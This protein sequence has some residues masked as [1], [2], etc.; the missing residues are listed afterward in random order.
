MLVQ[1]TRLNDGRR[2]ARNL[3]SFLIA[4]MGVSFFAWGILAQGLELNESKRSNDPNELSRS[5]DSRHIN[6]YSLTGRPCIAL[7][8]FVTIQPINKN[9]YG[10]WITASN[11][12]GQS[13]RI[14]VCYHKTDDCIVMNVPPYDNANAVLGIQPSMKE[15]QYDAKEK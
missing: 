8:T 6:R 13:I 15:F 11:S 7:G 4:F 3:P 1:N 12:C 9:I 14:Q 10:H 5:N 2:L